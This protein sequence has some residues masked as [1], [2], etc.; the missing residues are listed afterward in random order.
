[1]KA[2]SSKHK[3]AE[4]EKRILCIV[5]LVLGGIFFPINGTS[6]SASELLYQPVNPSFG[7][8]PANGSVLLN[9][10]TV[11]NAFTA[12][13]K[14]PLQT[15]SDNLNSQMLSRLA[16]QIVSKAF[17]GN[18][19]TGL[20]PGHYQMG[21]YTVDVVADSDNLGFTVNIVDATTN[22]QTSVHVPYQ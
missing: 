12:P 7:G 22:N 3:E 8:N 5:C 2:F 20:Q 18:S 10:A 11:Q 14:D 17:G 9:E 15:F 4:M 21:N 19:D 16:S 1:M 6:V 13:K